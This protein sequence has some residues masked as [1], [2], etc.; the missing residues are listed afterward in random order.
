LVID[1]AACDL[2]GV[3]GSFAANRAEGSIPGF[4]DDIFTLPHGAIL[5]R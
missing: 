3:L 1:T 4:S 5:T 2:R